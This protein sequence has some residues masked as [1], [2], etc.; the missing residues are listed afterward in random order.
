V[1]MITSQEWL[2]P[3]RAIGLVAYGT[4]V[5]CC[6]V[7]WVRTKARRASQLAAVLMFIDSALLLDMA[8]NWRWKLH[9]LFM[10]L[11]Q[12]AHEYAVRRP[13]QVIVLV[14]LIVLL[15][16]ALR[17]VRRFFRGRGIVLAVSG[18]VLSLVLWCIEV[19][20]LH[21]VDHVLYHRLGPIMA[22]SLLWIVA[23]LMTSIGMLLVSHHAEP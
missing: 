21:Q 9:Q 2:N 18:V 12:R 11:A 4:A 20:S 6:G 3:T 8:F 17:A 19:I 22:V 5:T 13:P 10:D 1:F 23:C 15:L 14:V 16:L 7:A